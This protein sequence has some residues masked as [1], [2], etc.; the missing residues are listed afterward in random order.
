M[1]NQKPVEEVRIG[2]VK[3]TV[4]RNGTDEQPRYNVTFSRLY[5]EGDE[6]KSTQSFGRNDLL[7]LAKVADLVHTRI[8]QLPAETET[9]GGSSRQ[10]LAGKPA[11]GARRSRLLSPRLDFFF[12]LRL[13]ELAANLAFLKPIAEGSALGT[14]ELGK[15]RLHTLPARRAHA[16]ERGLAAITDALR[17]AMDYFSLK[18]VD[19][20]RPLATRPGQGDRSGNHARVLAGY[21]RKPE[22]SCP[23]AYRRG[24]PGADERA[25]ARGPGSGKTRGACASHRLSVALKTRECPRHPG[26]GLQPARGSRYPAVRLRDP[27]R[28]R[29]AGRDRAHLSRAGHATGQHQFTGRA[30]RPDDDV[31]RDVNTARR[32]NCCA[33]RVFRQ[34]RRTNGVSGAGRVPLDLV[35][36]YQGHRLGPVRADISTGRANAR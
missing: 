5:K 14:F 32:W 8:F 18:E 35:D 27:D 26:P 15:L 11:P 2:R 31:F 7:V 25:G 12:P 19:F 6:W 28:Q 1:A 34:R 21:R 10:V 16:R 24:R 9:P 3:A 17:L 33:A 30:E 20:L 29:C 4:W 36:E 22:E 23:A 13:R